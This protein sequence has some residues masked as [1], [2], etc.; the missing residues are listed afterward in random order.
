MIVIFNQGRMDFQKV[1]TRIYLAYIFMLISCEAC[2][3][4]NRFS[5]YFNEIN[6]IE[7]LYVLKKIQLFSILNCTI[8][9]VKMQLNYLANVTTAHTIQQ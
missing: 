5:D 1:Q 7:Q 8:R 6:Y 2:V 9:I 4:A 3:Q